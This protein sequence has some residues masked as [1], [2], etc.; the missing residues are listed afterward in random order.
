[1]VLIT[2]RHV[3][4]LPLIILV[5]HV[6]LYHLRRH[7]IPLFWIM[8][9]AV[10]LRTLGKLFSGRVMGLFILLL[11]RFRSDHLK[12]LPGWK[13]WWGG[14]AIGAIP[15]IFL[16]LRFQQLVPDADKLFLKTIDTLYTKCNNH[17]ILLPTIFVATVPA[18]ATRHRSFHGETRI[19]ERSGARSRPITGT[20]ARPWWAERSLVPFLMGHS[21]L[22]SWRVI[23]TGH[24]LVIPLVIARQVLAILQR[25]AS[26]SDRENL[27]KTD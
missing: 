26:V 1:M 11:R 12:R 14:A 23:R 9:V 13:R 15:A 4:Q 19:V 17:V 6:I 24:I 27:I 7:V 8:I 18:T 25:A 3:V 21:C 10:V 22:L 5:S 16:I 20:V 2:M